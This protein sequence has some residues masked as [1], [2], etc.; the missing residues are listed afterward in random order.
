MWRGTYRN[1]SFYGGCKWMGWFTDSDTIWLSGYERGWRGHLFFVTGLL[2]SVMRM[3]W[4]LRQIAYLRNWRSLERNLAIM[5]APTRGQNTLELDDNQGSE[6]VPR[7]TCRMRESRP[8]HRSS[9]RNHLSCG[10]E[11]PCQHRKG[12]T[13]VRA[14]MLN[15]SSS[16]LGP[17]LCYAVQPS[18][19]YHHPV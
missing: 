17:D 14:R 15:A 9:R 7:Q 11:P 1:L 8:M 4:S 12:R 6:A 3:A 16:A 2:R 18:I 19:D 10:V 13:R 5:I